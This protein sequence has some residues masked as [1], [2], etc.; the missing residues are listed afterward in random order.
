MDEKMEKLLDF[1]M[2]LIETSRETLREAWDE[3]RRLRAE[4]RQL[5]AQLIELMEAKVSESGR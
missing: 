5:K 3:N 2:T 4:I 1:L